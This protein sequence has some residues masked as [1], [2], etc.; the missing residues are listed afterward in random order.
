MVRNIPDTIPADQVER[1][2]ED[3][4]VE[5]HDET[6][7]FHV[8]AAL[9][10]P[11]SVV[12]SL[13]SSDGY[14]APTKQKVSTATKSILSPVGPISQQNAPIAPMT[15]P[16]KR[17]S[18]SPRSKA[19]LVSSEKRINDKITGSGA[20]GA[21]INPSTS[22]KMSRPD[23]T[24]PR[25]P[26][27]QR[28]QA[29]DLEP[30][31]AP[32]AMPPLRSTEDESDIAPGRR[33]VNLTTEAD[34]VGLPQ[35]LAASHGSTLATE[36]NTSD[37][38]KIDARDK[39]KQKRTPSLPIARFGSEL[40]DSDNT[41]PKDRSASLEG[42][43]KNFRESPSQASTPLPRHET[44]PTST[45]PIS[46]ETKT[47]TAPTLLEAK[48]KTQSSQLPLPAAAPKPRAKTQI[49]LWIITRDPLYTEE[50]WDDGKFTGTPLA[51]F[52]EGIAEALQRS[53]AHIEKIKLTLQTPMSHTKITVC[54][55]AEDSWVE[56]KATFVEK[57][58][59]ARKLARGD[60]TGCKIL[61]EPFWEKGEEA[62]GGLD[63]EEAEFEF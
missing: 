48:P 41:H 35:S 47:S 27:I 9:A 4:D 1:L 22:A 29:Q 59:E 3:S 2:I 12:I 63:D 57:L 49:P 14:T 13:D 61:V 26:R 58:K 56:A 40:A 39:D 43:W 8:T 44:L 38:N 25:S 60:M 31:T 51:T 32:P 23:R 45:E 55:D 21:Q 17:K 6:D 10:T 33:S 53:A 46:N 7:Y 15:G 24:M 37:M 30:G 42:R 62:N 36:H 52:L 16:E 50:R 34:G 20:D 11:E 19:P 5:S 54:R 18:Y 28:H